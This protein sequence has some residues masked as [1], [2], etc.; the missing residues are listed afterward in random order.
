[1]KFVVHLREKSKGQIEVEAENSQDA[2]G[3]VKRL[4]HMKRLPP[5][6]ME[7]STG[8]VVTFTEEV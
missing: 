1:M 5:G 2:I 3:K 8:I 6:T 4:I 7:E